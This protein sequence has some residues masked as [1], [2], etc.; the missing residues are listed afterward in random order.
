MVALMEK[1]DAQLKAALKARDIGE[2]MKVLMPRVR[3]RADGKEVNI[4]VRAKLAK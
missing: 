1:S 4:A 2:V 3:G